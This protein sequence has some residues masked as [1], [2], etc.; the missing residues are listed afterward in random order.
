MA[1][2]CRGFYI[3]GQSDKDVVLRYLLFHGCVLP[4][5]YSDIILGFR[6]SQIAI[7]KIKM[8]TEYSMW[9]WQERRNE[10]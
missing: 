1:P 4:Y 5:L 8:N 7:N 2:D 6:T 3:S 10:V 9:K